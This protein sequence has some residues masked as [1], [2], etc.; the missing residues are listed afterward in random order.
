MYLNDYELDLLERAGKKTC[1]NYWE[2]VTWRSAEELDGFITSDDLMEIVADLVCEIDRLEEKIEDMKQ[3]EDEKEIEEAM[4]EY[5][6][7]EV[8]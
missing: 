7:T 1:T 5:E 4:K 6:E 2:K 8:L 3:T